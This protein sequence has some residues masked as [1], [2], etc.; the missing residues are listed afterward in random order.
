MFL[1]KAYCGNESE[2]MLEEVLKHGYI[3]ASDLII[4]T[5]KR[6]QESP[7]KYMIWKYIF[8]KYIFLFYLIIKLFTAVLYNI[9]IYMYNV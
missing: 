1:V 7:C 6:I 2:I 4:K 3:A 5:Y 8:F 9:I